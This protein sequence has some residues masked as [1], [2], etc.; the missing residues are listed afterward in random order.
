MT[1]VSRKCLGR[2]SLALIPVMAATFVAAGS[3]FAIDTRYRDYGPIV[4]NDATLDGSM[5][6]TNARIDEQYESEALI[7]QLQAP[8]VD[9]RRMAQVAS[10]TLL[11][12][13]AGPDPVDGEFG[14]GV[15]DGRSLNESLLAFSLERATTGGDLYIQIA[16]AASQPGREIDSDTFTLV[17]AMLGDRWTVEE[18]RHALDQA[19]SAFGTRVNDGSTLEVSLVALNQRLRELEAQEQ[20]LTAQGQPPITGGSF[21]TF[22]LAVSR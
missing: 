7:A 21:D 16:E 18:L 22:A 2:S 14:L 11:P 10:A 20:V 1:G 9:Q 8:V 15:H 19:K 5:L 13:A 4:Q 17:A 3:A 6:V 12:S